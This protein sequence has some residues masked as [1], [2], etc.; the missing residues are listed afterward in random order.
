MDFSLVY[1]YND[2]QTSAKVNWYILVRLSFT[3][4]HAETRLR[5]IL[6]VFWLQGGTGQK[7]FVCFPLCAMLGI[8]TGNKQ[9]S[10]SACR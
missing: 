2:Q 5:L 4:A 6:T 9:K 7:C 8:W 3:K 1:Q 10:S